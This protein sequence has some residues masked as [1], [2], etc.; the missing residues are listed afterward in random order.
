MQKFFISSYKRLK[1]GRK[2]VFIYAENLNDAYNKVLVD[3]VHL[4][5]LDFI[6]SEKNV[7]A[8][9]GKD[10]LSRFK[11]FNEEYIENEEN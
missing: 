5:D 6:D 1:N 7:I 10:I 8:R 9:F 2:C 4:D 11:P 3:G